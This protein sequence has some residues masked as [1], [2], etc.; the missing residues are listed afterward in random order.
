MD[1]IFN[2]IIEDRMRVWDH[3]NSKKRVSISNKKPNPV[4]TISREYGAPGAALAAYM[5]EKIGF[6][7]WDKEILGAIADKL[8]RDQKF[9]ESL[10]EVRREAIEDMVFGFVQNINTNAKFIHTLQKVVITIEEHGNSIIVGRGA[11]YICQQQTSLHVRIVSPFK[12]RMAYIAEKEGISEEKALSLIKKTDTERTEFI[13]YYF[14]K[15]VNKSSDY[16]LILNA[17]SYDL[18]EMMQIIMNAYKIKTGKTLKI[19]N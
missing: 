8:G 5:G 17:G 16:D 7:V 4:I 9:L 15:D 1:K 13:K 11:N 12:Q 19:L 6:K 14:N 18:D 2:K 10:D 3:D